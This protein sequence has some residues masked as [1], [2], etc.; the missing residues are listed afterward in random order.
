MK[1]VIN[2]AYY[3]FK[4]LLKSKVLTNVIFLGIALLLVS[5]VASEITYGVPHKVALDFG[6]GTLTLSTVAISILMGS[7]L[8]SN[9]I[10]QRTIFMILSRP[11][12][13]WEYI[14]GKI[15]GIL[16]IL[17]I[18]MIL[19]GSIIVGFFMTLGGEVSASI[20]YSLIFILFEGFLSLLIVLNFSL[21][22]NKTLS[23]IFTFF[24]F[25]SGHFVSDV[26]IRKFEARPIIGTILSNYHYILPRF[27][28]FN[29]KDHVVHGEYIDPSIIFSSLVYCILFSIALILLS[30]W[31][32]GNKNID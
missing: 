10:D 32:L 21:I 27:D 15:L 29:F 3:T 1:Q 20:F 12:R 18:N 31:I 7:S 24:F 30:C 26:V 23:I 4:D 6:L 8:I 13:R 16:C 17:I 19:L 11:V 22:T 28:K 14:V 9:E 25:V 5:Y 2:V